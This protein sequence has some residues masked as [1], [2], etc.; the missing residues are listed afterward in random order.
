MIFQRVTHDEK[1]DTVSRIFVEPI[2]W[3][4]LCWSHY[5]E[6]IRVKRDNERNFY[7]LEA[8]KN[9]WSVRELA[10]QKD[11]LLFDRLQNSKDP[12]AMLK[13]CQDGEEKD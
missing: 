7:A 13:L 3:P 10:R 11:T 6:L 8:S 2:F 1:S 5:V 4:N 9:N 12:E